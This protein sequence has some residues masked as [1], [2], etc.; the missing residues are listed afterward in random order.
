MEVL[1]QIS[2]NLEMSLYHV[3]LD[4]RNHITSSS[5]LILGHPTDFLIEIISSFYDTIVIGPSISTTSSSSKEILRNMRKQNTK[6]VKVHI[7]P[8]DPSSQTSNNLKK[9][10]YVT[11][12]LSMIN[13]WPHNRYLMSAKL[14][15]DFPSVLIGTTVT[16][17]SK[18]KSSHM[19]DSFLEDEF[20]ESIGILIY[21]INLFTRFVVNSPHPILF[22]ANTKQENDINSF[23][24]TLYPNADYFNLPK[25]PW[26]PVI[27]TTLGFCWED[28]SPKMVSTE[29]TDSIFRDI[30]SHQ[31][32][33]YFSYQQLSHFNQTS[34]ISHSTE[35]T[36]D[37]CTS[38]P[39][40]ATNVN[41]KPRL[42][43]KI[44]SSTKEKIQLKEGDESFSLSL[45]EGGLLTACIYLVDSLRN[46][47]DNFL[48]AIM[49]ISV[50]DDPNVN[51]ENKK[52]RIS[53]FTRYFMSCLI[54][55]METLYLLSESI[56]S[57]DCVYDMIDCEYDIVL[58][59]VFSHC[60]SLNYESRLEFLDLSFMDNGISIIMNLLLK[61]GLSILEI[62][63][64]MRVRLTLVNPSLIAAEQIQNTQ[65]QLINDELVASFMIWIKKYFISSPT[66]K[67]SNL[68][69][70]LKSI[71]LVVES[72]IDFSSSQSIIQLS[73]IFDKR[74]SVDSI[75]KT[76]KP[77]FHISTITS[78]K[79]TKG[80]T[81]EQ[82]SL[83][84]KC[85][86]WVYEIQGSAAWAGFFD[87][88]LR[89]YFDPSIQIIDSTITKCLEHIMNLVRIHVEVFD[90]SH[91]SDRSMEY[92]LCQIFFIKF[93]SVCFQL[94]PLSTATILRKL[95]VWSLLFGPYF[96]FGGESAINSLLNKEYFVMSISRNLDN[97]EKISWSI[98][99]L[100]TDI[101]ATSHIS[102]AYAWVALKDCILDFAA[103]IIEFRF[104][105]DTTAN[106]KMTEE[107]ESI[108]SVTCTNISKLSLSTVFSSYQIV[109]WINKLYSD[110]GE[111]VWNS[112]NH[113]FRLCCITFSFDMI[114]LHLELM[115]ATQVTISSSSS[116]SSSKRDMNKLSSQVVWP[117]LSVVIDF[118]IILFADAAFHD[119]N[120]WLE[121]FFVT[122][123][124]VQGDKK[125]GD[126]ATSSK[127]TKIISNNNDMFSFSSLPNISTTF[128]LFRSTKLEAEKSNPQY[129]DSFAGKSR[130][131]ILETLLLDSRCQHISITLLTKIVRTCGLEILAL[132]KNTSH[133]DPIIREYCLKT[134]AIY[135]VE[136]LIEITRLTI[137]YPKT[138]ESYQ[139]A[140]ICTSSLVDILMKSNF[141]KTIQDFFKKS[142]SI[143]GIL[144]SIMSLNK[145][146]ENF[147]SDTMEKG[148][149]TLL[150]IL[151]HGL[152]L[153]TCLM[154]RNDQIKNHFSSMLVFDITPTNKFSLI[155]PA[156]TPSS[157]A[158]IDQSPKKKKTKAGDVSMRAFANLIKDI[159][160][161][162]SLET[163]IILLEMLVD[164]LIDRT[165]VLN[166]NFDISLGLFLDENEETKISNDIVIAIIYAVLPYCDIKL[167][168]FIFKSLRNLLSGR[169]AL[170]NLATCANSQ[171]PLLDMSLDLFLSIDDVAQDELVQILQ[172]LGKHSISV[173][174]MKHLFRIMQTTNDTRPGYSWRVLE[175]IILIY[176]IHHSIHNLVNIVVGTT[177]DDT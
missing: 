46:L 67:T 58:S 94:Y 149:P 44:S 141:E 114:N 121:L 90:P 164:K 51:I 19:A 34:E 132:E 57:L 174:Q 55:Q 147:D 5:T 78:E 157:S 9:L 134:L 8:S 173:S 177:R 14:G 48:N 49:E 168:V 176:R 85:Y 71:D 105:S 148:K 30:Y 129:M 142:D 35:V 137:V 26:N 131:K 75:A 3:I 11:K 18:L 29:T 138:L 62:N 25:L 123:S 10:Y 68:I 21:L 77:L 99:N 122:S 38:I 101:D 69:P 73:S 144:A 111:I 43:K 80:R 22:Y 170:V 117:C 53:K 108:N 66:M 135:V 153:L 165:S 97:I 102:S 155:V 32:S 27:W 103:K 146:N 91:N 104:G 167:K 118:L 88:F 152:T 143:S 56:D 87:S 24:S 154:I 120:D 113:H 84:L 47:M 93:L 100:P 133:P 151:K 140:L 52:L 139:I 150:K 79:L 76:M 126:K 125:S 161:P 60:V 41:T 106:S 63:E 54:L 74:K 145:T 70:M 15:T 130:V 95:N 171:P 40:T 20:V 156:A 6:I 116:S 2:Q 162:I 16:I 31:T 175:V 7:S 107:I 81:L 96:M 128:P 59:C 98:K 39:Y 127:D 65:I 166:P 13:F 64:I 28:E 159:D 17:I 12:A 158:L 82:L 109:K 172:V 163:L 36:D 50:T 115:R 112:G 61:R 160:S 33:K 119:N 110:N 45:K 83:M 4:S 169:S 1:Q 23:S 124:S 42:E 37:T 92:P 72:Q 89:S 86:D 136:R